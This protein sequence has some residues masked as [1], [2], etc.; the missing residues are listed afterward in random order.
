MILLIITLLITI[1]YL[2]KIPGEDFSDLRITKPQEPVV[3]T[4]DSLFE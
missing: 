2:S 1:F 3:T 4:F